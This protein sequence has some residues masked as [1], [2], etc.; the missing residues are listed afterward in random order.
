MEKI[1]ALL[2]DKKVRTICLV[3]LVAIIVVVFLI[4]FV[5]NGYKRQVKALAKAGKDENK[6]EKFVKNKLDLKAIY[7]LGKAEY[8]SDKNK[9]DLD[10]FKEEYKDANK[11]DYASDDV[12]EQWSKYYNAIFEQDDDQKIVVKKIGSLKDTSKDDGRLNV[13]GMKR[14]KV[15]LENKKADKDDDDDEKTAKV[16]AYFWKGKL[17][18]LGPQGY[19]SLF[20]YSSSLL[21]Y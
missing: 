15:T 16:Y 12:I 9:V 6:I 1:K 10:S 3:A 5:A 13:K 18:F 7:A 21:D 20:S 8:D 14:A 2:A 4:V 19:F 17:V 11:D